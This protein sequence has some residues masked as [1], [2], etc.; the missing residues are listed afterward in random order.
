MSDTMYKIVDVEN[1]KASDYFLET[2]DRKGITCYVVLV[3]LWYKSERYNKWIVCNAGDV[4]DGAT[5]AYDIDSFGWLF[6]DDLCNT[7]KFQDGTKCNNLQASHVVSDI[8]EEEGHWFRTHSWFITTWL[9]GG[10]KAR[11]N[12]MY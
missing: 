6:H 1:N 7:G 5:G 2:K 4:S 3:D 9:F 10:G 12:G 8:L 11:K